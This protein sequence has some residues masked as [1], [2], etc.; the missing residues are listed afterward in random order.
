MM[1]YFALFRGDAYMKNLLVLFTLLSGT[2]AADYQEERGYCC[3]KDGPGAR[4][5][6]YNSS[7]PTPETSCKSACDMDKSCTGF[8]HQS[9]TLLCELFNFELVRQYCFVEEENCFIKLEATSILTSTTVTLSTLTPTSTSKTTSALA[10]TKTMSS[11][12]TKPY[13]TIFTKSTIKNI[14]SPTNNVGSSSSFDTQAS[15][16]SSTV[17]SSVS[18]PDT[19]MSSGT[20]NTLQLTSSSTVSSSGTK[21]SERNMTSKSHSSTTETSTWTFTSRVSSESGAKSNRSTILSI[22]VPIVAGALLLCL[23]FV[24]IRRCRDQKEETV[25]EAMAYDT[26]PDRGML[27]NPGFGDTY[28]TDLKIPVI[29]MDDNDY[30]EPVVSKGNDDHTNYTFANTTAAPPATKHDYLAPV[31]GLGR[32]SY[33]EPE[34]PGDSRRQIV[35]YAEP[36]YNNNGQ[37]SNPDNRKRLPTYE[38]P[39]RRVPTYDQARGSMVDDDDPR[40]EYAESATNDSSAKAAYEMAKIN[41]GDY[42]LAPGSKMKDE[43]DK[44][45]SGY[46]EY[47]GRNSGFYEFAEGLEN[48]EGESEKTNSGYYEFAGSKAEA[49]K[50]LSDGSYANVKRQSSQSDDYDIPGPESFHPGDNRASGVYDFFQGGDEYANAKDNEYENTK[51]G[52]DHEYENT[53]GDPTDMSGYDVPTPGPLAQHKITKRVKSFGN[54]HQLVEGSENAENNQR[55]DADDMNGC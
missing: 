7:S 15:A 26:L 2:L 21:S 16:V 12:K 18:Q 44:H 20:L 40:Y 48:S 43:D 49:S 28:I 41:F 33:A 24:L 39:R 38:E 53:K 37:S 9:K 36:E 1:R 27:T 55:S 31:S 45:H 8:Q 13:S 50:R 42:G 17:S 35:S 6:A 52:D 23:I 47:A 5:S 51:G 22:V 29:K 46:Y 4:P 10:V 25:P 3:G 34:K 30:L 19:T 14:A 11:T 32:A 54:Q